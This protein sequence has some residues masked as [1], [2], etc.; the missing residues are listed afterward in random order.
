MLSV[1]I[2]E[3]VIDMY[4]GSPLRYVSILLI[5]LFIFTV[6]ST[7]RYLVRRRTARLFGCQPIAGSAT[8]DPFLGLDA[9]PVLIRAVS[10]HKAL[11]ASTELFSKLGSTFTAKEL[12]SRV[13]ATTE[14]ENI[15]AILSTNF[16]DYGIGFRLEYFGPLLGAGIFDTDGDHWAASRA[17]VRPNFA[18]DQVAD[19]TSFESLIQD[20]FALLPRDGHTVVDLQELFFRYTIDSAT[21]FLFGQSVGSLRM[22]ESELGF[23]EAFSYA[24]QAI[25][26]RAMLG[27]L[28]VFYRDAKADRCNNICRSFARQFVEKAVRAVESE[29]QQQKQTASDA[30]F[31][32]KVQVETDGSEKA[33][34]IFS[35]ALAR[36]ISDKERILDELMNILLA[37]RDTTAS[38]L[39]NMFFMLA[40]HPLCWDKLRNEVASLDGRPPTY[41]QLRNL[42]YVQYCLNE[43]RSLPFLALP[44]YL[45][46]R[47]D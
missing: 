12:L 24:Q 30:D 31:A 13:I 9:I 21:D 2:G 32:A 47:L 8:R 40:K 42:K 22:N 19:L 44:S 17:L 34:Y 28:K 20:M 25:M 46:N 3:P 29:K 26:T 14:P 23:A 39:S 41:E 33:K 43:C 15:K 1:A 4:T 10:Q 27:P 37:G 11:E 45:W 5:A 18:R 7:R 36:H 38:L 6:F 35:Q 16:K